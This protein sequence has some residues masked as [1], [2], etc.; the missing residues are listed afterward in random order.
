LNR[1]FYAQNLW[2]WKIGKK[3][4]TLALGKGFDLTSLRESEWS[5]EFEYL[6]RNRLIQGVP[7]YGKLGDKNK[8]QYDRIESIVYRLKQYVETGNLEYLVDVANLCLVEFVEGRHPKR[9]FR[10][11]DDGDHVEEKH[12]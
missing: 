10:A 1:K 7:R 6:M 8:P 9:H 11:I 5:K 2:F 3:E 12:E 4:I